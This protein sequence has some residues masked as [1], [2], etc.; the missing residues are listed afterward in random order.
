M[1]EFQH[2]LKPSQKRKLEQHIV[3]SM[4]HDNME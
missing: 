1:E 2:K 3:N 4:I